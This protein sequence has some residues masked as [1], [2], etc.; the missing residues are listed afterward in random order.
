MEQLLTYLV[1]FAKVAGV[2][3]GLLLLYV[4]AF[5]TESEEHTLQNSLET[6]WIRLDDQRARNVSRQTVFLRSIAGLASRGMDTV[7]GDRLLSL[8][9]IAV[10]TCWSIA[11][12]FVYLF[13]KQVIVLFANPG[14]V[15]DVLWPERSMPDWQVFAVYPGMAA[16]FLACAALPLRIRRRRLQQACY[17]GLIILSLPYV[18]FLSFVTAV[19]PYY[20]G[21]DAETSLLIAGS[22]GVLVAGAFRGELAVAEY[23][24]VLFAVVIGLSSFAGDALFVAF[25]R[26]VLRLAS[27]APALWK[28][29]TLVFLNMTIAAALLIIPQLVGDDIWVVGK[30]PPETIRTW[31]KVFAATNLLDACIAAI[32]LFLCLLMLVHWLVWP[33]A[34]RPI[35]ALQKLGVIRRSGLLA[36]VGIGLIAAATGRMPAL[37]DKVVEAIQR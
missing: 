17:V 22:P 18:P 36:T 31:L 14:W 5:L 11:S 19:S 28:I 4:A 21:S 32:F 23:G 33:F 30:S 27:A 7:L 25:T 3:A 24:Y 12:L 29:V 26:I 9:A 1:L 37:I 35:Y 16:A 2:L 34:Q 13:L 15:P 6:W 10:S 8:R 20:D